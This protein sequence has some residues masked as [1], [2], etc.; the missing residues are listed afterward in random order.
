MCKAKKKKE[1]SLFSVCEDMAVAGMEQ[2]LLGRPS[3]DDETYVLGIWNAMVGEIKP[4][5]KDSLME[6][7]NEEGIQDENQRLVVL[8]V[9][10]RLGIRVEGV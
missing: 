9:L 7:L 1:L 2:S 8:S 6:I 5:S 3:V 4:L 10:V